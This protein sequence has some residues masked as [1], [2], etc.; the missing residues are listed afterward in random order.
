MNHPHSKF[1]LPTRPGVVHYVSHRPA[2]PDGRPLEVAVLAC[3]AHEQV[4]AYVRLHPHIEKSSSGDTL[5]GGSI[6]R[7]LGADDETKF[8]G[9]ATDDL[10]SFLPQQV[11]GWHDD[12]QQQQPAPT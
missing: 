10:V 11:I 6:V 5:L 12:L 4:K 8:D 9:M 2:T 7:F 1:T 3:A